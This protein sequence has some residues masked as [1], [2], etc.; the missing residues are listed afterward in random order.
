M[1]KLYSSREIETVLSK[2]GY[3]FSAQEGSHG[4]FKNN[5]GRS[6][7][8]PMNK[9]EIPTGTF[10]SILRQSGLKLEQFKML[11]KK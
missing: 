2:L 11:L 9:K 4:K 7:I 3:L 8:L 10:H 5:D 6:V 1:P